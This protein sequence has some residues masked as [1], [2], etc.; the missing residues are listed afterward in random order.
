M[1]AR[2]D[3]LARIIEHIAVLTRDVNARGNYPFK[4]RRLSRGQMNLLFALSRSDGQNV[5]DLARA[6]G[7]T[8]GAV[9]QTVDALRAAGLLTSEVRASD[10]RERIIRL[11]D[12]ARAEVSDFENAYFDAV[13]PRF[14]GLSTDDL[15]QLDRILGSLGA[16]KTLS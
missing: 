16:T 6:L 10:R 9:S 15:I 3:A 2:R 1:E 4:E 7:V 8:N 5:S 13:A 11:T 12:G 14:E